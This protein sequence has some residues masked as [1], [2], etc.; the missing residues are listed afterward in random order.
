M[1]CQKVISY[2]KTI[3]SIPRMSG[4][5]QAVSDYIMEFAKERGLEA[6]RDGMNNV[7]VK[8]PA[9]ES[10][11]DETVILQGHLDMVYVK[12]EDSTH[13]YEDGIKIKENE[14]FYYAGDTTLGEDNGIAVAY[15]LAVLDSEELKHPNLEVIFTA[16]EEVGLAGADAM[17]ISTLKGN[18]FIN[19]DSEEEG[20][21][22][23]SCA[24]GLR[25]RMYWDIETKRQEGTY[26]MWKVSLHE[27]KGGHS[28][29]N[30]S[31][32]RGNAIV[33]LGRILQG[34]RE[35][36]VKT[37]QIHFPGKANAIPSMGSLCVY[38]EPE[39]REAVEKKLAGLEAVFKKE[40]QYTDTIAIKM[41][42]AVV[43]NPETYTEELQE[44]LINSLVLLPNG[45][46]TYSQSMEG[47]VESSMNLGAL[48]D[49]DGRMMLLA[50]IR[51]SVASRKYELRDKLYII[52]QTFCDDCTFENDYPGWEFRRES[53]LRDL[54]V[55]IYEE[56]FGKKAEVAAIHAGLE[57]GY[58]DD[59]KPGMDIISMGPDMYDVHSPEERVS[60]Q[61][62]ENMWRFLVALL[63]RLAN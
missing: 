3:S 53:M 2:F 63:E 51:S 22:Y 18:K 54:S 9:T 45:V 57:C 24:G 49:E 30:I 10:G 23:A 34:L 4:D 52:A 32:G 31:M 37:A 14:E 29:M 59:K 6:V 58:W 7:I 38:A 25:C 41:E 11:C 46:F 19:L 62:V 39:K 35:L 8:K 33:L 42:E 20:I 12:T 1:D 47:L 5:E 40:L 13:R 21:F 28:G 56:L 15:C 48:S 44:K 55:E 17:D 61:S 36:D 27:L 16:Q 60:K 26:H 50:M 43:E